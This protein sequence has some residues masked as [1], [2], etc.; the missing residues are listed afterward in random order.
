MDDAAL[1]QLTVL[2]SLSQQYRAQGLQVILR[3][4]SPDTHLFSTEA[5]RNAMTDLDLEGITVEHSSGTV[6]ERTIL[7]THG[8]RIAAQWDGFA[9]PVQLGLALRRAI[10]EPVYAHMGEKSDE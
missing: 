10:G 2:K 4:T 1:Q 9:G 3:I 7:S 6:S 5:F 8:G